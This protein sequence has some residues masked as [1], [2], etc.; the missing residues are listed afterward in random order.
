[1]IE[2][3]NPPDWDEDDLERLKGKLND[4]L[5]FWP[6]D[7]Y[8]FDFIKTPDYMNCDREPM[9]PSW[10]VINTKQGAF[11][12]G[13]IDRKELMDEAD[14]EYFEGLAKVGKV[15]KAV[16]KGRTAF[17]LRRTGV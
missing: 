14:V 7:L 2:I 5:E 13:L 17:D 11:F 6:S 4:L 8:Y 16:Q 1:M 3:L 10:F 9:T 15:L 12:V